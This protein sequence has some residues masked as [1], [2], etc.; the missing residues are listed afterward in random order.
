MFHLIRKKSNYLSD[1]VLKN[2]IFLA[3]IMIIGT[4]VLTQILLQTGGG[5]RDEPIDLSDQV[6]GFYIIHITG[7]NIN[8]VKKV[9]IVK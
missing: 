4:T 6:Q 9:F 5:V 7:T 1:K 3:A 2:L 8:R